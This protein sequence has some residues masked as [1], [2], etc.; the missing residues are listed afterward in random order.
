[1][2]IEDLQAGKLAIYE[3]M[4]EESAVN[5]WEKY[6]NVRKSARATWGSW[7]LLCTPRCSDAQFFSCTRRELKIAFDVG[8]KAVLTSCV[9]I[10]QSILSRKR[11]KAGA[12]KRKVPDDAMVNACFS[13]V[14]PT[15]FFF[16]R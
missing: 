14:S 5:Y 13:F 7:I 15:F 4:A 8:Q 6:G 2:P 1:M 12:D 9:L 10:N 16:R 11:K 3:L